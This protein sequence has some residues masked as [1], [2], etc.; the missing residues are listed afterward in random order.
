MIGETLGHYRIE[1]KLGEGGMGVVYKARDV[2]LNRTVA[3]KVLPPEPVA[4]TERRQRFIQEAHAAS[5]LDHPNIVT[6]YD[7][8]EAGGQYF[9]V[10]QYVAGKT[11]R[12]LLARGTALPLHDAL[13]YA[14]QIADALAR[15]HGR[16]IVHRDLKPE[17]VMITAENQV[18]ILDFGLAKLT[19]AA[20]SDDDE[21]LTYERVGFETEEGRVL[22]TAAYMSPEQA[23][24]KK[25]DARSDIFA[26]GSL[27]YEMVTGRQ[28]FRGENRLT[29]LSSIVRDE[30]ERPAVLAPALPLELERLI[31]RAL[32]KDP[33]RRW[34][35][36]A[37]ARVALTEMKE[38]SESGG[39]VAGAQPLVQVPR[40]R[41]RAWIVA[42]SALLLLLVA[43]VVWF[44]FSRQQSVAP[45]ALKVVP[46]TSF[47]GREID[48][49]LSPNGDQVAFAWNGEAGDNFD[50]YVQLIGSGA[51]LRLTSHVAAELG[52]AWSPDGR[53]IAF[54]RE[55]SGGREIC[56]V[57]ALGGPERVVGRTART[58]LA[59]SWTTITTGSALAWSPDGK[60]LVVVDQA[61]PEEPDALF[62]V[63]IET[64]EKHRLAS[65]SQEH[66]GD[67]FPAFSPDGKTLAFV[68]FRSVQANDIYLQPLG[69]GATPQGEPRRLTFDG[70]VIFGLAWSPDGRS[71][72]FSSDRDASRSLWRIS[73]S[74]TAAS[75]PERLASMENAYSPSISPRGRLVYTQQTF[76]RNIWQL[77][78]A[79]PASGSRRRESSPAR[80]IASTRDDT[81]PQFSPDGTRVAFASDRSGREEIWICDSD[82]RNQSPLTAFN[83]PRTGSPRWSPDGRQIAFDSLVD[84]QRDVYAVS[85]Q[86][87][88]PRRITTETSEEVRP[89]WSRDGRWI[90]FGSNRTGTWQVWKAPA[91]GGPARQVTTG[92]GREA[93]ESPD[94]RFVYYHKRD[95]PGVWRVP[96]E[97]GEQTRVL[98]SGLQ[99][100]WAVV[101]DGIYLLNPGAATRPTIDFFNFVTRR[102]TTVAELSREGIPP[103]GFG[104]T[105]LAV[106]PD[107][108]QLLYLRLDQIQSDL[109]LV[110]NFW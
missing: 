39:E 2:H 91:E 55:S 61:S 68:H 81:S 33:E 101:K 94:G 64:G 45:P 10:M 109:M 88:R 42:G 110:E 104:L 24:G 47:A 29:V 98:E 59:R 108:R 11:L 18:K 99:G 51:P 90:Y 79:D 38:E 72:V 56:I 96:V 16:G 48:P 4:N 27:L 103:G 67:E 23:Q 25:V 28:A 49:A 83:G 7:L 35:S 92:G 84:G 69:P 100:H 50:I 37:D 32:R 76:D 71:I 97:G 52:P 12:A 65:P 43:G 46:L 20:H 93:F 82:G 1:S 41:G 86:G 13:R 31:L 80:L 74:G 22:G 14:I 63:S 5:A 8:A 40:R 87:G 6:I 95:T 30:P 66:S 77:D 44:R 26:F 70:R 105:A 78:A 89:S 15:A 54:Y 36:M 19:E 85:V 75:A 57:P 60:F 107:A 58:W 62:L 9:I 106:S 34:Q 17:N 73:V 53:H 102:L 21:T 3:I